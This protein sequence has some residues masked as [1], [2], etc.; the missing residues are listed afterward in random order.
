[1]TDRSIV[2]SVPFGRG[3]VEFTL[4]PG[5]TGHVA[6]SRTVPTIA[7]PLEA[8][9]AAIKRPFGAESLRELARG[10]RRICIAVTDATRACPDHL[11]VPPILEEL[12]AAGVPDEAI[13]VLV[14]V[15][16]HRAST[17]AEKREKL[18]SEIV[19]RFRV[20]D[21]DASDQ[22]NLVRVA[23]GPEG[24]P[25]LINRIAIEAD[26]LMA[27]GRVEP[28]QYA[29][30]SGGGKTVAIGCAG[31]E[32]IA[33]TH[34]PALLDL[35]GTRLG[36]L[37]GNPFQEAVRRVARSARV[38]FV[39]NVV[40]DDDGRLVGIA[41]GAPEPVQDRLA[42]EASAMY[43]V[44]ISNQVDIAVAGVG[45]PK[46]A[47][48]YQASRAAS[49]LQY[50]P[51]PVVRPGGVIIIPAACPEGAGTGAGE[52]RFKAAMSQPGGP[53]AVIARALAH[54][55]RPGEQRAYIMARV[56]QDVTVIVAGADDPAQVR[57]VG[58]VS[59][60][61]VDEALAIAK[62]HVGIPATALVVP[63]AL[64]TLPIVQAPAIVG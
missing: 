15:G 24:V 13:T 11:I 33:Y 46:D 23:E 5:V 7:N 17:D 53:G 61:S 38:A 8:A 50:A 4:P 30:Y 47:N 43:T 32:I 26:L 35:P 54:G 51:T 14:A 49:Y 18:G 9:A 52:Q 41:Y 57:A 25:F 62:A 28:H 2:Y 10:K 19:D 12:A 39:G 55:I 64:L 27:T 59:A 42:A 58:C 37:D 60:A 3:N 48:L 44:P 16:A 56:L 31:E 1:M 20:V 29:G 34:G 21:H 40:L 45:Y 36:K 63:H 22:R 6:T